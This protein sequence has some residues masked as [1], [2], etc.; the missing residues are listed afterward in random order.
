MIERELIPDEI[1]IRKTI[2]ERMRELELLRAIL[3][4][5]A[6]YRQQKNGGVS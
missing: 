2:A 4:A 1:V 3:R 5:L 6:K